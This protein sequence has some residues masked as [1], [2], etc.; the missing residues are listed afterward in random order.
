MAIT[1]FLYP[2]SALNSGEIDRQFGEITKPL[3]A[4]IGAAALV[5]PF[6]AMGMM[7]EVTAPVASSKASFRNSYNN[8]GKLTDVYINDY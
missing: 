5:E 6:G 7:T 1:P 2:E 3:A 4:E 8:D